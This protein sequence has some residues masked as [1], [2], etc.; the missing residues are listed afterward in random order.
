MRIPK[1]ELKAVVFDLDGTLL[2][3]MTGHAEAWRVVLADEG[4]MIETEFVLQNEGRF[5]W[6]YIA[7]R[8]GAAA[9]S[10]TEET[11][12]RLAGRQRDLYL[13]RFAAG[14]RF[15]P[16]AEDLL[17]R[18]KGAG[19]G[20]AL[21]T[22]ST[23]A[24]LPPHVRDVLD[25]F[26]DVLVTGDMVIHRKPHPEPYQKALDQLG[27]PADRALAVENAPA[28]IESARAA[29]LRTVAVP[30]TLAREYLRG[31]DGI[32]ENYERIWDLID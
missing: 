9:E 18:L 32:L 13:E 23:Q 27:V 1:N 12:I 5:D 16:G 26:F 17:G 20:L 6:D 19:L 4:V 10:V 11:F 31:A 8:M 28:G 2:D 24:V 14:V 3:S 22:S 29:G 25:R 21:V 15:Y 30:T 7:A